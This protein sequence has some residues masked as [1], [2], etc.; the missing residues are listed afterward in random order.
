[1]PCSD[2]K[3]CKIIGLYK[4][5]GMTLCFYRIISSSFLGSAIL[6]HPFLH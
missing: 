2:A 3:F 5:T 4:K 1:M 6:D